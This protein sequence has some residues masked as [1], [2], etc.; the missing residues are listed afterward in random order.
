MLLSM[1]HDA[2]TRRKK[3]TNVFWKLR[4]NPRDY[5]RF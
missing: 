1:L 2:S 5:I 3:F 4:C